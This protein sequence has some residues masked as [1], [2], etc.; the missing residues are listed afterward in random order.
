MSPFFLFLKLYFR[1]LTLE[2]HISRL[3][4]LP[5]R[6]FVSP[7]HKCEWMIDERLMDDGWEIDELWMNGGWMMDDGLVIYEILIDGL[8]MMD[9]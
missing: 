9:E 7:C 2:A 4:N 1:W 5:I 6:R 8:W 3:E